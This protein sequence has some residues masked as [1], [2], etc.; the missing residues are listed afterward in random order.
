[1]QERVYR[2]NPD[3]VEGDAEEYRWTLEDHRQ[4][5]KVAIGRVS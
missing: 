5:E 1:V 3:F 4:L 2:K